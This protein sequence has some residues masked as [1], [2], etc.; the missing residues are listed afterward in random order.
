MTPVSLNARPVRVG[1]GPKNLLL[2]KMV[3]PET[4]SLEVLAARQNSNLH[5]AGLWDG[6]AEAIKPLGE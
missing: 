2:L 6:V 5:W 1:R 4:L 3:Q